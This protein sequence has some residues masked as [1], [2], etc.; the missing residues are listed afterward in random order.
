M[1][2]FAFVR[3][4][5]LGAFLV[6]RKFRFQCFKIAFSEELSG[7]KY[8]GKSVMLLWGSIRCNLSRDLQVIK[9]T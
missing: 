2:F 7:K 3:D 9:K 6:I 5:A 8:T 4:L 1:N